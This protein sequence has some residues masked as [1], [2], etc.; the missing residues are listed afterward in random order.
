MKTGEMKERYDVRYVKMPPTDKTAKHYHYLQI[1]PRS[2]QD[3]R[4]F[5]EARVALNRSNFLPRTLWLQQ[6]NDDEVT[7]DFPRLNAD[8][9]RPQ[10]FAAPEVPSGWKLERVQR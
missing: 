4:T 2:E 3:K 10:H 8:E 9:L 7:W 1:V 5:K 6:P